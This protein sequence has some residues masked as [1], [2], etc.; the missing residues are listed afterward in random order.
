MQ[1]LLIV[2]PQLKTERA[3]THATFANLI[4][5]VKF[6]NFQVAVIARSVK[7]L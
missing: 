7:W 4:H 5:F 1:L 6:Q 2:F 3:E